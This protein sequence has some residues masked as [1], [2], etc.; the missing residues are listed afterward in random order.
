MERRHLE[1]VTRIRTNIVHRDRCRHE[2]LWQQGGNQFLGRRAVSWQCGKCW[3]KEKRPHAQR[4]SS[5]ASDPLRGC[6]SARKTHSQFEGLCKGLVIRRGHK[7]ANMA[8]AHRM[9]EKEPESTLCRHKELTCAL[10]VRARDIAGAYTSSNMLSWSLLKRATC[11][12]TPEATYRAQPALWLAITWARLGSD[13][14]PTSMW[15][16]ARGPR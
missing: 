10:T 8:V 7:R 14:N 15:G 4:Q 11:R 2:P 5:C 6:P 16:A 1:A 9:L 12:H 3:K 13:T